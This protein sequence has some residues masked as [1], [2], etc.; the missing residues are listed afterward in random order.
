LEDIVAAEATHSGE[1]DIAFGLIFFSSSEAPQSGDKYRLVL[2]SAKFADRHGFASVWIPERHF[3]KDG[4]LYPNPAVL[5]AALARETQR[6]A[7]RAGSVVMPL[8]NPLRVAE[9]WAM[10]DNLSGGRV[11]ISFA[12]GWHPNDFALL[13]ENYARRNEAMY[14]GI[15]TVQKLWRGEAVQVAGGDGKLV[16]LHTY[17]PPVQPELPIWITAA[18]NPKTFSGAGEIGAHLLTHLY[19]H[20]ID[21]LAEKIAL[22]RQARAQHGYD[23]QTGQVTVMIHTFVSEDSAM[24][25]RA[26]AT[27]C[28]YLRSASYL[29]NAIGTSRGQRVD[30]STLSEQDI[31]DYLAFVYERLASTQRV[32][33]S[34][35]TGGLEVVERLYAAGVN[36]VACQMDFGLDVDVVLNSMPYLN[37]LKEL[38]NT[39]PPEPPKSSEAPVFVELPA[40]VSSGVAAHSSPNTNGSYTTSTTST[41]T[42]TSNGHGAVLTAAPTSNALADVQQRCREEVDIAAFYQRLEAHG[43]QLAGSFR[44]ISA[45]WRRENEALGQIAGTDHA[46]ASTSS[47]GYQSYQ[48]PPA[49]LDA[50]FQVLIAALPV[51]LAT[52]DALYLPVGLRRFRMHK[53][54]GGRVWSHAQVQAGGVPNVEQ[55]EGDVRILDEQGQ[56]L[57]EA[58]GL[59]LQR[60]APLLQPT[61]ADTLRDLL[62]EL[63]WEPK[64]LAPSSST[65]A[66][67]WVIFM[68]S[69]GVGQQLADQ[70]V[71][72]GH[73]CILVFA[74]YTYRVLRA[75]EQYSINPAQPEQFQRVLQAILATTARTSM[76]WRGVLHLWSLDTAP[77]AETSLATLEADSV[78]S[79]GS[80]LHLV[81]AIVNAQLR[82]APRLWFVTSGVQAIGAAATLSVAQSPLWGLGRTCA[83][84][85]PELW[86]GL[87][88]LE[89]GEAAE[90]CAA[91]LLSAVAQAANEDQLAFRQGQSYV[92]RLVR[93]ASGSQRTLR[94]RADASYLITGGL[95]GLGYEVA[96]WLARQ[97]AR[98]LLLV[99]RTRLPAR[100]NWDS[101]DTGSRVARLVANIRELEAL[102]VQVQ[103]AA[104]DVADEAQL[105][106][107]VQRQQRPIRG[108]VHA[109]SVWQDEQGQ[110]LVRPLIS[111]NETALQAVFRPKVLGSWLLSKLFQGKELDFFVSFSSGA[112]L[113]GSAAQGNYAAAGTFLDTL[114][115]A[116]RALGQPALSID[117]G[118][119]SETGF[120]ATADGQRVHEY[121]E[122][123]GIQ[124]ITPQQVLAALGLLVSQPVAQVGVLKLDW[125]L[126]QEF[127][128]QLGTLPLL[129]ALVTPGKAKAPQAS[130]ILQQLAVEAD[131]S[132]AHADGVQQHGPALL[133]AYLAEKVAAVLRLPLAKID[134]EQPLTALGLDSLMAI[135]LKNNIELELGVHIPIVAFLQGPSIRQFAAQLLELLP[136]M[137]TLALVETEPVAATETAVGTDVSRP[138]D[139]LSQALAAMQPG[140]AEQLLSNLENLSD[141]EVN[142]LLGTLL[143]EG[144]HEDKQSTPTN[145]T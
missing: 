35:P 25:E 112:S 5:Q 23:P 19:N 57:I 128:P 68:D 18:G 79:V 92:A 1:R 43:V 118:A 125:Q 66:G 58:F 6:I 26:R 52:D 137:P 50:C 106:A 38:S 3:T 21:E 49:L 65:A 116:M 13:P 132:S 64:Q 134:V 142:S 120:G 60:S 62:Y 67:T 88:D 70:L 90:Q 37:Q 97:G 101:L 34:T 4:W 47:V 61:Q 138:L 108:I 91:H 115:H 100:D 98:S 40:Y 33:F 83:I 87:I 51:D 24:L 14:E 31:A 95:W 12:S 114:A 102:G 53:Q 111:L 122:S 145:L 69:Q 29:L 39:K 130:S 74:G 76:P 48:M 32:L 44:S 129:S 28:D 72:Q 2:E 16:T 136:T 81:Q 126:L 140:E 127:Y 8:H 133:E 110:S 109:A 10:V 20:T 7:L 78:L 119:V 77:A 121:W 113:F 99:G 104:L 15:Q 56:L 86:G 94:L 46:G 30:L 55:I 27:F 22:Y 9:E 89:I 93:R 141:D 96:C 143:Q 42:M 41:P 103:Y 131:G 84:E 45:L 144:K 107:F 105:T 17:P 36:E 135:E 124:R 63:V 75:G 123:H 117:W 54:P 59:R 71:A 139:D 85:H 82:D 73:R 80:A 11:G